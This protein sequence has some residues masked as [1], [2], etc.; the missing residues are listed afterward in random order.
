[1][2]EKARAFQ[3]MFPPIAT[4]FVD[5]QVAL[6]H[7]RENLARWNETDLAGYVVVG[8]NGENV[9]LDDK[10]KA[11]VVRAARDA[12]PADK[13]LIVGTG[14]QST[15]ATIAAT[16][17]AADLGADGA[18]VITPSY[19]RSA[20]TDEAFIRH[21][22]AL[23]DASPIPIL[24]YNVSKFTGVVI[25][26]ATVAELAAH[27]RIVGIKDSDG[28]VAQLID[29]VRLCPPDF[30]VLVGNAPA[31]FSGLGV[32]AV[33]GI[34]A[35]ANVAPRECVTIKRLCD[36]GRWDEA[37]AIHFRLLP[38]GRAVTSQF[39]IGG[40]K[41]ALDLLGYYGGP[42]RSPLAYPRP[43]V[44]EEIRRILIEA[45]LLT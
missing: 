39:G 12:I 22:S 2:N 14:A 18:L 16:R 42:P 36:E 24:I 20:M 15:R 34:L 8:S 26:P 43:E 32:G 4:P 29:L 33:G 37:R 38:V 45:G 17:R 6:D 44:V 7:L 31:Y 10:E 23:A 28:N 1:M 35:L 9:L 11:A 13:T 25:S 40:F 30:H 3:G 21:Y 5:D 19:Y 27:P 41:A